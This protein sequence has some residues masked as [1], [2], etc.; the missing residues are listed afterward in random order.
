M[1]A[2]KEVE[3]FCQP[4]EDKPV[5][6]VAIVCAGLATSIGRASVDVIRKASVTSVLFVA[7]FPA[8]AADTTFVVLHAVDLH[9]KSHI[10]KLRRGGLQRQKAPTEAKQDGNDAVL[11]NLTV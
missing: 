7:S 1:L 2:A 3:D 11:H 9:V 10:G 5:K 4:I 8:V 6:T